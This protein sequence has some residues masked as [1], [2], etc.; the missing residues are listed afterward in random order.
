MLGGGTENDPKRLVDHP[1]TLRQH[2]LVPYSCLRGYD[3]EC[4]ASYLSRCGSRTLTGHSG[5]S[6]VGAR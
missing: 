1:C 2:G 5:S 4:V 3:S 6:V